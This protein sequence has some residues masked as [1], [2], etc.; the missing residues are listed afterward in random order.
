[1]EAKNK[2]KKMITTLDEL[3]EKR[4]GKI[5]TKKRTEFEI[6]ARSFASEEI[7]EEEIRLAK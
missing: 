1:M 5:G 2:S 3:I 7:I 6:K 4:H